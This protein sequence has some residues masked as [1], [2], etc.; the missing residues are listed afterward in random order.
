[1]RASIA[2][3]LGL[4][5]LLAG[6]T[7]AGVPSG[8]DGATTTPASD[9][10][11]QASATATCQPPPP[12]H[13]DLPVCPPPAGTGE[14]CDVGVAEGAFFDVA[15]NGSHGF[16]RICFEL[17]PSDGGGNAP[18]AVAMMTDGRVLLSVPVAG[19]YV[20]SAATAGYCYDSV[21]RSVHHDGDGRHAVTLEQGGDWY[22]V[23]A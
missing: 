7:Q 13:D 3:G 20:I 12:Q 23:C 11:T 10:T 22:T 4:A 14:D 16:E 18:L 5:L 6:C 17:R 15:F 2:A 8:G 21:Y 1:M 9:T 19:E